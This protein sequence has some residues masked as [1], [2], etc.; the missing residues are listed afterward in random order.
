MPFTKDIIIETNDLAIT[1]Q[2]EIKFI[3]IIFE[4]YD[5]D[6]TIALDK[7]EAIEFAKAILQQ[8]ENLK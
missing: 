7:K 8:A 4:S 6:G 5:L 2:N 3:Q 1:V